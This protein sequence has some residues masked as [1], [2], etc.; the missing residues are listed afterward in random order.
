MKGITVQVK[1]INSDQI[2]EPIKFNKTIELIQSKQEMGLIK[3]S[4]DSQS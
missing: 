4:H 2:M 3:T 1:V